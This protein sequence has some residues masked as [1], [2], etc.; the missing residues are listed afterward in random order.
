MRIK[1]FI[2]LLL[3][4]FNLNS[5]PAWKL[6]LDQQK[7]HW[8]DI[9]SPMSYPNNILLADL[10]KME[11]INTYTYILPIAMLNSK[12][13][14]WLSP[15]TWLKVDCNAKKG[16][17]LGEYTNGIFSLASNPTVYHSRSVGYTLVRMICGTE[18]DDK[19]LIYGVFGSQVGNSFTYYGI[20]LQEIELNFS[21]NSA[22]DLK[23]YEYDLVSGKTGIMAKYTFDCKK[24]TAFSQYEPNKIIDIT[25]AAGTYKYMSK[26]S[27]DYAE[28]NLWSKTT[29]QK[30]T[31]DLNQTNEKCIALGLKEKTEK[32]E[33]CV[34]QLT[35]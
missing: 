9:G 27:C 29:L 19:R 2:L 10:T 6:P 5:Q 33:N 16:E 7:W 28:K 17:N 25:S 13:N 21:N 22:I 12:D 34:L 30:V 20:I 15:L 18:S 31:R 8:V 26:I 3:T 1:F 11:K 14:K 4:C 35:K 24:Q 23:L 32:F